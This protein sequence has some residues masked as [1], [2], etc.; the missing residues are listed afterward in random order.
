[1]L[2]GHTDGQQADCDGWIGQAVLV[3]QR[4]TYFSSKLK[5]IILMCMSAD[6]HVE[7]FEKLTELVHV[8][9]AVDGC[10]KVCI[11]TSVRASVVLRS[12]HPETKGIAS[13]I[14]IHFQH[15]SKG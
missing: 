8:L 14:L 2:Q 5:N 1:M 11:D 3:P 9:K 12:M 6:L 10:V 13:S 4:G 7:I 15:C